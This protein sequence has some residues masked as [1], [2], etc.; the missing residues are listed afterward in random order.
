MLTK[1][2]STIKIK[3]FFLYL[4]LNLEKDDT[5]YN[6]LSNLITG[7]DNSEK[8]KIYVM[9]QI[10]MKVLVQSP[11]MLGYYLEIYFT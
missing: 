2:F 11:S 8:N 3:K 9:D 6:K 1:K 10:K 7:Y 4:E 5:F